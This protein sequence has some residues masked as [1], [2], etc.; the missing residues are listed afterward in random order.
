MALSREDYLNAVNGLNSQQQNRSPN[1]ASQI[2]PDVLAG[3]Q[4]RLSPW[5][6]GNTDAGG[7]G[8]FVMKTL[9]MLDMPRSA[10]A[11]TIQE[12]VDLF[13]GE[14]F[15]GSD[16]LQQTREH[17]GFG[18]IIADMGID[19]GLGGWG[20]RIIGFVGDVATDPL[21]WLGGLNVYSRARGARGLI[22]DITPRIGE[23]RKAGQ[24]TPELRALEDAVKAASKGKS[25]SA[26][27]NVLVRQHGDVGAQLVKD[28]GIDTGL[29]FRVPGTG[30]V[31]GRMSRSTPF[32]GLSSARRAGQVPAYTQRRLAESLGDESW[33]NLIRTAARKEA[34]TEGVSPAVQQVAR[35]AAYMP[36]EFSVPVLGGVFGTIQALPG[37]LVG[38]A[39]VSRLGQGMGKTFGT[40]Q[41]NMAAKL[42]RSD[43]VE[44][45]ILSH[46]M[47]KGNMRGDTMA[48]RWQAVS[49]DANIRFANHMNQDFGLT[50]DTLLGRIILEV[51][52][53]EAAL[54]D[55]GTLS[56]ARA[57]NL[58]QKYG[59][60]V[61]RIAQIRSTW[62][63]MVGDPL[64]KFLLR[65]DV[66]TSTGRVSKQFDEMLL[67]EGG[68]SPHTLFQDEVGGFRSA[69]ELL[70]NIWGNVP[71]R[72]PAWVKGILEPD[73]PYAKVNTAAEARERMSSRHLQERSLKPTY[74]DSDG[75]LQLGTQLDIP[76]KNDPTRSV[77]FKLRRKTMQAG[78]DEVRF[79]KYMVWDEAD[80]RFNMSTTEQI[81]YAFREAG[82][83]GPNE[84]VYTR[85]YAKRQSGYASSLGRDVRLAV[86][87]RHLADNGILFNAET[88][89]EYFAVMKQYD[90][91]AEKVAAQIAKL[92]AKAQSKMEETV[93]L[94][95]VESGLRHTVKN[96]KKW[97]AKASA[98]R[99][100]AALGIDK[101]LEPLDDF[102]GGTSARMFI[103]DLIKTGQI[104]EDGIR[105][106]IKEITGSVAESN[107]LLV[108]LNAI[109]K[110][111][112]SLL[113]KT[114]MYPE[115]SVIVKEAD[116]SF[117]IRHGLEDPNA[118]DAAKE[119]LY[120]PGLNQID[121]VREL[122]PI[123][124][125]L[126]KFSARSD[127]INNGLEK[128]GAVIDD[129]ETLA[130]DGK[131]FLSV[132]AAGI[133]DNMKLVQEMVEDI[134]VNMKKMMLADETVE[135]MEDLQRFYRGDY[136]VYYP[137]QMYQS[138]R[139]L[140]DSFS[141][142][143]KG[144]RQKTLGDW[145]QDGG[146]NLP[147]SRRELNTVNKFEGHPRAAE[148]NDIVEEYLQL[149]KEFPE[150]RLLIGADFT[151]SPIMGR[152]RPDEKRIA[153]RA[154]ALEA[155]QHFHTIEVTWNINETIL[156]GK[157]NLPVEAQKRAV[158]IAE[159]WMNNTILLH[160]DM[161]GRVLVGEVPA[162]I[163]ALEILRK[164]ES[165]TL[166][167]R[168]AT[169]QGNVPANPSAFDSGLGYGGMYEAGEAAEIAAGEAANV[170]R[171]PNVVPEA[172]SA[173]YRGTPPPRLEEIFESPVGKTSKA[174]GVNTEL[175]YKGGYGEGSLR[176]YLSFVEQRLPRITSPQAA[177]RI[178]DEVI[179]PVLFPSHR[180]MLTPYSDLTPGIKDVRYLGYEG[181]YSRDFIRLREA[182]EEL[183]G[184]G[185]YADGPPE[186]LGRKL[187][188]AATGRA[189][190]TEDTL[191]DAIRRDKLSEPFEA[192]EQ[193]VRKTRL[194]QNLERALKDIK[195]KE[196]VERIVISEGEENYSRWKF[197]GRS[198]FRTASGNEP[199]HSDVLGG[200]TTGS[201]PLS[202]DVFSRSQ[203]G[204]P[205][206]IRR[207][208]I[209]TYKQDGMVPNQQGGLVKV[210]KTRQGWRA[211]GPDV[212]PSEQVGRVQDIGPKVNDP[213]EWVATFKELNAEVGHE[214]SLSVL[215]KDMYARTPQLL[216]DLVE[217]INVLRNTGGRT[218]ALVDETGA[219]VDRVT[220]RAV[221]RQTVDSLFTP[222]KA[223]NVL[224]SF[225]ESVVS[226]LGPNPSLDDIHNLF[227]RIAAE[228]MSG[229]HMFTQSGELTYV[230]PQVKME[231]VIEIADLVKGFDLKL[232]AAR[233]AYHGVLD[234]M[235][236]EQTDRLI[237]LQRRY[238]EATA[239][240]Q[241]RTVAV[242]AAEQKLLDAER[243][244]LQSLTNKEILETQRLMSL[245]RQAKEHD[246]FVSETFGGGKGLFDEVDLTGLTTKQFQELLKDD[247]LMWGAWRIAGDQEFADQVT[248]A[249][250]AVQK[251]N[252]RQQVNAF[253]KQFDRTHNWLKA[254]MVATPGFVTRNIMGGMFNM[255]TE[256]IPLS[257]T[258]RTGKMIKKAYQEGSGD[259]LAGLRA[260]DQTPEVQ[261]AIQLVDMGAH[262]GGQAASMVEHNLRL[263]RK[264]EWIFGT[265]DGA[266]KGWRINL[267]PA[268]A[269]FALY[270]GVRHANTYAEEMLR[271]AT[272]IHAMKVGG[273]LDD[274]IDMIYRLHFNYGNLSSRE[275]DW[276]KRLFPFYTWSRNNLPLQMTQMARNPRRYNRLLSIKRNLE[277]GTEEEGTVPSYFLEPFGFRMPF[278]IAGSQV[279]S[280]PDLPFQDLLRFDPTGVGF[281]DAA[282][283]ILSA[284]S[285]MIKVPLEYWG[286]KQFFKGIPYSGRYQQVPVVW[287]NIP[288]LMPALST[289]GWA[290]K[291]NRG[292]WK[293]TDQRIAVMDGLMPYIGRL[294]RA[295]PNERRYQER[296]VQ[297]LVS[298]LGGM[299]VRINTPYEQEMQ[300]IRDIIERDE[301][302]Q[303][304]EDIRFRQ[305]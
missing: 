12:T 222:E 144:R 65:D 33:E 2:T 212:I 83:I 150:A 159:R 224:R 58:E 234:Q 7:V 266:A 106:L 255:W 200:L 125:R 245:N 59:M 242:T 85:G 109:R 99:E 295:V 67:M 39:A 122:V 225:Q 279:Y 119:L 188:E 50:D 146:H 156:A 130:P 124:E 53:E 168:V 26:A 284:G 215:G 271:L 112:D 52:D 104:S 259:L 71:D 258:L 292:E 179:M 76:Y 141:T 189:Q 166:T 157:S 127:V 238:A 41:D 31:L 209:S 164:L 210:E 121:A 256:D 17:H 249:L 201:E 182:W 10:I 270:S 3:V 293:M 136:S 87:E 38:R 143:L 211:G 97:R 117:S 23:L 148:L 40:P 237:K 247:S 173:L 264:M 281:V 152:L 19:A 304:A 60:S 206:R 92:D 48:A 287:R 183:Y 69:R 288:G 230:R 24:A 82:W 228:N 167:S 263:T 80:P 91:Y 131:G 107:T 120:G 223:P 6:T 285:P 176:G 198:G 135:G 44:E 35:R 98:D 231:D 47:R 243:A 153:S 302:L 45:V 137:G 56:S 286:G 46:I 185:R 22:D 25:V 142:R 250:L 217:K 260:M 103:T 66:Y 138:S 187:D 96:T 8:G 165:P 84:S 291:N 265:K 232:P 192:L 128:L 151:D 123:A 257:A 51:S 216:K 9:S 195:F 202:S 63:E 42:A 294:R 246:V 239:R 54:I 272:G 180:R 74:V 68:Y 162:R 78:V 116:G 171:K 236:G 129:L 115:G 113:I 88:F 190:R 1:L 275:S 126:Q 233:K 229:T 191:R 14:G 177:E 178:W 20:N 194:Q 55:A 197:Y 278:S 79:S 241:S 62:K 95:T 169:G 89:D 101:I 118:A 213:K 219:L 18:D 158:D 289:I 100:A 90:E 208:P 276:F 86:N 110:E 154:S 267:N 37:S 161:S 204:Q 203:F 199:L 220:V 300:R 64:T 29:K 280:V 277:Y 16:W 70:E 160:A 147:Q 299:S 227:E 73:V 297:T 15:S 72:L 181:P 218:A 184:V 75:V 133:A 30:P 13:Q 273:S 105:V 244:A 4:E 207:E 94:A 174:S 240:E 172:E 34:F 114:G 61:Q 214:F 140:F 253:L 261:F 28:L 296:V 196:N 193:R 93:T 221:P 43:K 170:I 303:D 11:S 283:H 108:E 262:G 274:A 155:F 248:Y 132:P 49:G 251:M 205:I 27:R 139:E 81:D 21:M 298:T 102:L 305:R 226:E 36:V 269:Q 186:T 32:V 163:Q 254:Q 145:F 301:A 5:T 252:D 268:D 149:V 77:R 282:Q 111:L 57:A 290:E 175:A 134:G 235:L